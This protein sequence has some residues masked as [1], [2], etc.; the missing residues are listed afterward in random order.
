VTINKPSIKSWLC[1][2]EN[3]KSKNKNR[4]HFHAQY[5]CLKDGVMEGIGEP[6][7]F[8]DTKSM[9]RFCTEASTHGIIWQKEQ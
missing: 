6:E 1:K 9:N 7:V 3:C 4:K 8:T 2:D 5:L